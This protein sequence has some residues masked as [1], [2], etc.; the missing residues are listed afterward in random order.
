M[1]ATHRRHPVGAIG[2]PAKPVVETL[3]QVPPL[4]ETPRHG[5]GRQVRG[6]LGIRCQRPHQDEFPGT[7]AQA[8]S[9]IRDERAVQRSG[10]GSREPPGRHQPGLHPARDRSPGE[11]EQASRTHRFRNR[12]SDHAMAMPRA[13]AAIGRTQAPA[14]R[15]GPPAR[16]RAPL[17]SATASRTSSRRRASAAARARASDSR[18]T[19]FPQVPFPQV[20]HP[21]LRPTPARRARSQDG[22]R[23]AA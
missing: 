17:T 5:G 14:L 10:A 15:R 22:C 21:R 3:P 6:G 11:E 12:R 13:P 19:T 18:L 9:Q 20:H 7:G 2:R 4:L 1:V 23:R 16:S 8:V